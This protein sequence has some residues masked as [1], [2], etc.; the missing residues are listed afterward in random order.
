MSE[1]LKKYKFK[2]V[3]AQGS[4]TDRFTLYLE[5]R[6]DLMPEWDS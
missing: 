3:V 4:Q 5:I 6:V 1:E 2:P